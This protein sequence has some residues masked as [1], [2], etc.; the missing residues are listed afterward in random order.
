M[1]GGASRGKASD[2]ISRML[3][4]DFPTLHAVTTEDGFLVEARTT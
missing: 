2:A 4:R 3:A 1:S